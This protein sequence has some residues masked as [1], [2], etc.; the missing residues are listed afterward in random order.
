LNIKLV[1]LLTLTLSFYVLVFS[2]D[3]NKSQKLVSPVSEKLSTKNNTQ[4]D[5]KG[6][7][8]AMWN[9]G[10]GPVQGS[11]SEIAKSFLHSQ[12]PKFKMTDD[13]SD[14]EEKTVQKSPAGTHVRFVQKVGSVPVYNSDV[15][16]SISENNIVNFVVNNYKPML[17]FVDTVP[18]LSSNQALIKAETQLGVTGKLFGE[19]SSTLMIYPA[20]NNVRLAYR[21]GIPSFEPRGDWEVFVDA[22]TGEILSVKDLTLFHHKSNDIKPQNTFTSGTTNLTTQPGI[23]NIV[24]QISI[25]NITQTLR[26]LEAFGQRYVMASPSPD[27]LARS[28][29]WII[30]Q[31][32]S[33]GYTNITQ[34]QFTYS[35]RN[36]QNIIVTKPGLAFPDTS[37]LLIGHYDSVN[38]P[39]LN[40]NGTGVALI[41]EAARVLFQKSFKYTIQFICF[42][43]EEQGL[44]G[45]LAYVQN[46]VVPQQQKIK[47]VINM[48]E[49][50]GIV[51]N[52]TSIVKVEKDI[53]IN[54]PTNNA[55]SA[56]YTDTLVTL[57]TLY[58]SLQTTITQAYGSDYMSFEDA[59][60]V[61]TGFYE[62][63]ATPYYHTIQDSL[64][65]VDT[66]YT[67]QITKAAT[68]GVAYFAQLTPAGYV[69]DPDPLTTA[70]AIYG[71]PGF[72]DNNDST[73]QQLDSQRVLVVLKDLKFQNG[74]YFL[75]GPFVK[76]T[77]WDAPIKP[78]ASSADP[79][80][81]KFNRSEDGFE[82]VMVY[83]FIDSC[84]RY[85][86]HLGFYGVQNT[87]I[88]VDSHGMN[89]TDNSAYY[90]STNQ[91]TYGEGGVDDA[92][93]VD[94]IL[95]E[96]GHAV[97]YGI[98][99]NWNYNGEQ[100][101]LS[102]GFGDYW[103]ASYSRKRGYWNSSDPQYSWV[104]NWDGHNDFWD[105]RILN[106]APLYP[107]GIRNDA[108][109]DGQMWST[110]LIN[111]WNDIGAEAID[112][113]VVQSFYYLASSGVTMTTASQAVIQA[114]R[115]LYNG[116]HLQP[117]IKWF[118]QRGFINQY[119]YL[120]RII[121][122]LLKDNELV[123]GSYAVNAEIDPGMAPLDSSSLKVIWGRN[124][125]FS[126]TS[127]LHSTGI[128]NQYSASILGNGQIG[129]YKYYI[130]A[131]DTANLYS[132]SPANA[133]TEFHSFYVGPDTIK[134]TITHTRIIDQAR[135]NFPLLIKLKAT[136][137][138]AVDSV[139]V[140]YR[141]L[142]ENQIGS[143]ALMRTVA[144]SFAGY[145]PFDTSAVNID[146]SIYYRIG[147]KDSSVAGNVS[148]LPVSNYFSFKILGTT[149]VADNYSEI[150]KSFDLTQNY[151]NPFNPT[152]VIKYKI[153]K[154]SF[155]TLKVF[156]V[157][158]R[159]IVTLVSED[160]KIGS[161]EIE[162]A[163]TN[164]SSGIYYYRIT[165][166][167][168][169]K[170]R[171]MLLIR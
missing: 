14:L 64:V 168:F 152:T 114:D 136:D 31:F 123:S 107:S 102:E 25:A 35:G 130:V 49:I 99:P 121:H 61:I 158:G 108:Y 164:L 101:A 134:P 111:I 127:V 11:S 151:P 50:G 74:K 76:V 22:L 97:N 81:F 83:Y 96:Y 19:P 27:S 159:E 171:K 88:I 48:D 82:D 59:G 110:T 98:I 128:P 118:S 167:D 155:V 69:F 156:D 115:D 145:F 39:G 47:L 112:K 147:A 7:V 154:N 84:Q 75:E 18:K 55:A 87:P 120:P 143:F 138:I 21:V 86:Q 157:L 129:T 5:E 53:D 169:V 149:D 153:P 30:S 166:G 117:I 150:P 105:G 131:K 68:A 113:L 44:Q 43:A 34:H 104:F 54:P 66:N 90:S 33:F 36:L 77:D 63:N 162:Y 141:K 16:I 124:G 71:N 132:Y 80:S 126:D 170:I 10:Y 122:T 92:E 6:G 100:A 163:A 42:S 144:D 85:L 40:D 17:T 46:V 15:V 65:Y 4:V 38:G 78:V 20:D 72:T 103:A 73:S 29:D 41:L 26:R 58:S 109:K 3:L 93:D 56:L 135:L 116:A 62:Y 32:Q 60:Y 70:K 146:D 161:Y 125:I 91:L 8:R 165:A 67:T 2:Q 13:L 57:T 79:D 28:R 45:S 148:Y 37:V 1:S 133:P 140:E 52:P 106:Y 23:Q 24:N 137:N 160:K 9:I 142:S 12:S 95:H 139:W 89:G 51:T 94:V 119:N